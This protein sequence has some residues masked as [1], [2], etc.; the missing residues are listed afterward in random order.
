MDF[1]K[2]GDFRIKLADRRPQTIDSENGLLLYI[3]LF[4]YLY[5]VS[6]LVN[7]TNKNSLLT[8][9]PS[10]IFLTHD[11]SHSLFLIKFDLRYEA[12]YDDKSFML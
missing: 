3:L 2:H 5:F 10:L 8:L 4:I 7:F 11:V 1:A 12:C 6:M 9:L